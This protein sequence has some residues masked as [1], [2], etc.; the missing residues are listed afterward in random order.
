MNVGDKTG[1]CD[2]KCKFGYKESESTNHFWQSNVAFALIIFCFQ[3]VTES[4]QHNKNEWQNTERFC[5]F[6]WAAA[7]IRLHNRPVKSAVPPTHAVTSA[8]CQITS[9]PT[10]L[11]LS[12]SITSPGLSGSDEGPP[13]RAGREGAALPVPAVCLR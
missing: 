5:C 11:H 1:F 7:E 8:Q 2:D 10:N 12:L 9:L 3:F 13:R 6:L 4:S